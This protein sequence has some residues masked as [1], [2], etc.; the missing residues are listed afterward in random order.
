MSRATF[1]T[2][3]SSSCNKAMNV[4]MNGASSDELLIKMDL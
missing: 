4:G 1:F 3:R 2:A